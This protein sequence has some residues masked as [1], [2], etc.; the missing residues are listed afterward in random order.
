MEVAALFKV[1][2][3]AV[4]NWW[5]KWQAG[6]APQPTLASAGDTYRQPIPVTPLFTWPKRVHRRSCGIPCFPHLSGP[7]CL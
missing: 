2:V 3:K 6:G 4:D 5:A 1:S 7:D